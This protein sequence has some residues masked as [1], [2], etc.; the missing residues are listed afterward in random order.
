MSAPLLEVS[1]LRMH[2]PVHGGL[3]GR[4]VARVRAVD[5]VSLTVN[6]GETLGLVGESGCGKSTLGRT[7]C[8]S[9][10]P[11]RSASAAG[12]SRTSRS[13]S[14]ARCGARCR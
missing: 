9:P 2:F 7:G 13:A 12:R 11:A 4:E 10:P 6:E 8:S 14:C 1:D 5:G 3:L